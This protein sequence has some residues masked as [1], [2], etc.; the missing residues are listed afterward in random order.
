[1]ALI[2]SCHTII[3][4]KITNKSISIYTDSQ[5]AIDALSSHKIKSSLVLE[6]WNA[7]N[8]L[9]NSNTIQV[10]WVPGHSGI[11]GN[12]KADE[13][14]R[15]ATLMN[16][17]GPEPLVGLTSSTINRKIKELANKNFMKYWNDQPGCKDSKNNITLN[18]K[19]SKYLINLSRTRLK[20]YTGIMTGHFELNKHLA[21]I[22]KR[23]NPGC[24][25]CGEHIESAEHYLCH[26]PAFI[27]SRFKC[28]GRHITN[29]NSIKTLHPRNIL[30]Y[31]SSTGSFLQK[32]GV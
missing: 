7:L 15:L 10:I 13:L 3:D 18:K 16:H 26:C 17:I 9:T 19:Y 6:C 14:A 4:N 28:F 24:D 20:V 27:S 22:G 31:I 21:T 1:M 25:L 30:S 5:S 23:D 11:Q 8:K 29:Y 2:L 12:E 32:C